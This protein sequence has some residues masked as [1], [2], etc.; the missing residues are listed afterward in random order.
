MIEFALSNMPRLL[1]KMAAS[2]GL[3]LKDSMTE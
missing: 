3:A 1:K 2:I